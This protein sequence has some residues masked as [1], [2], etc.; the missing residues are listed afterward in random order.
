MKTT[1]ILTLSLLVSMLVSGQINIEPGPDV[2]PIDM[3]ENIVGEGI[4]YDNVTF[5]G[6][7]ASRG[8]FS[9]GGS[10]NIG[11]NSGIFLTSGAGYNIPGPNASTS[12]GSNNGMPGHASL[13]AITTS[14]TYDAAVL[15]FDFIPESDTLRFKYVF[16]SEEYN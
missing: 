13:N 11:I 4:Q 8:T 15:E 9:N 7:D 12:A 10:T 1:F 2:T 3:V 6:A 14:T 16:G 5:Q